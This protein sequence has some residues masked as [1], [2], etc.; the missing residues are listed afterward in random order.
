MTERWQTLSFTEL[1]SEDLYN[2]L[3]LR[4]E[5]FGVEQNCAYLDL[6]GL[7][8]QSMHMLYHIG[9]ELMAYQRCLPPGLAYEDSSMGRIVVRPEARGQQLGRDLVQRGIDFNLA[10]W[11][12]SNICISA[13]AH[14]QDFYASL[15]FVSEGENYMEDDIPHRKMR[16]FKGSL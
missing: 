5:V 7:D 11:P 2:A 12:K 1:P 13:Q 10:Q 6:D 16:Y 9:S 8:Q 14:L 4:Q 3:R 15:G